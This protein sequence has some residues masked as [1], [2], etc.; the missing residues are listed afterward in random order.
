MKYK[1]KLLNNNVQIP[2]TN[3][4]K[5]FLLLTKVK[6]PDGSQLKIG[7]ISL[8]PAFPLQCA[9]DFCVDAANAIDKLIR[10]ATEA[11]LPKSHIDIARMQIDKKI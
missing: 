1:L 2:K 10:D 8:N 6:L 7:S 4:K 3:Y 9:A 11:I 5:L